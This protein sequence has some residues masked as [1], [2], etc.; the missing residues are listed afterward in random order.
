MQAAARGIWRLR[1][2]HKP[3]RLGFAT[4]ASEARL[5]GWTWLA[6]VAKELEVWGLATV[7]SC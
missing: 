2:R 6:A 4:G 7:C 5:T 3:G 1:R